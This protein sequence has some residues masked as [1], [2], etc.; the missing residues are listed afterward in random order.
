MYFYVLVYN[1]IYTLY[2]HVVIFSCFK[3]KKI[4][5]RKTTTTTTTD[6]SCNK[7]ENIKIPIHRVCGHEVACL[8]PE[9]KINHEYTYTLSF[10]S[11]RTNTFKS[12]THFL[13]IFFCF[14]FLVLL[15]IPVEDSGFVYIQFRMSSIERRNTNQLMLLAKDERGCRKNFKFNDG[16]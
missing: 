15:K 8:L 13:S 1:R 10:Y 16:I 12:P 3:C 5:T 2:I 14:L 4:I 7:R 11:I 9:E 6:G